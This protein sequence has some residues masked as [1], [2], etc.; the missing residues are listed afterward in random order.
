M[1]AR[2]EVS[3]QNSGSKKREC[4]KYCCKTLVSRQIGSCRILFRFPLYPRAKETNSLTV[5]SAL[6]GH[7]RS[8]DEVSFKVGRD[9]LAHAK[10]QG[11]PADGASIAWAALEEAGFDLSVTAFEPMNRWFTG[12][13]MIRVAALL[14]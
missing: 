3:G 14:R 10:G 7:T 12:A 8:T 2:G 6:F 5:P 11:I 1:E 9:E 13:G 4:A